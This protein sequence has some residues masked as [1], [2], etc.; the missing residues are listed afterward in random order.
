MMTVASVGSLADAHWRTGYVQ[1][2]EFNVS[3][4]VFTAVV[5]LLFAEPVLR[6]V[7]ESDIKVVKSFDE[8]TFIRMLDATNRY[9]EILETWTFLLDDKYRSAFL[10]GLRVAAANGAEVRILLLHPE[11]EAAVQ[12]GQDLGRDAQAEIRRNLLHLQ[13]LAEDEKE[14]RFQVRLYSSIPSAQCYRRDEKFSF[15]L[16][17]PDKLSN[18]GEQLE[19]HERHNTAAW[20]KQ[21]FETQ[22]RA[23][24]T[25]SLVSYLYKDVEVVSEPGHTYRARYVVH[26]GVTYLHDQRLAAMAFASPNVSALVETA[27]RMPVELCGVLHVPAEVVGLSRAKYATDHKPFDDLFNIRVVPIEA[28]LA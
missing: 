4:G 15:T 20:I 2:L 7:R 5:M 25:I 12:R 19:I 27:P 23:D 21:Q 1:G 22:W 6:R 24:S 16:Y 8:E 14:G 3:G 18:E 13:S 17:V 10:R 9:V 26:D 11:S 28:T